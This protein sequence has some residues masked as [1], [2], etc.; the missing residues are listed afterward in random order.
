M[1]CGLVSVSICVMMSPAS[2]WHWPRW[3]LWSQGTGSKVRGRCSKTLS[4]WD[5]RHISSQEWEFQQQPGTDC[6]PPLS[7]LSTSPWF[8]FSLVSKPPVTFF[9]YFTELTRFAL[10][11]E[12]HFIVWNNANII[13]LNTTKLYNRPI[14][15]DWPIFSGKETLNLLGNHNLTMVA[16]VY[17]FLACQ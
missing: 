14:V 11:V 2:H 4:A 9:K 16:F 8:P 3:S 13:L 12:A 15:L 17:V 6:P 5:S 10:R 1:P 7:R